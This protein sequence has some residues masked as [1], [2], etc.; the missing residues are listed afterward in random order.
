MSR[1]RGF[2]WGGISWPFGPVR[3]GVRKAG[4][5]FRWG[6]TGRIGGRR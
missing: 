1:R 6:I 5:S 4:R 3:V 2:S